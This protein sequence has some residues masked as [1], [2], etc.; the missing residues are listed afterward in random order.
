MNHMEI[1][2]IESADATSKPTLGHCENCHS[3]VPFAD[4]P[5]WDVDAIAICAECLPKG[6]VDS[7]GWHEG[8]P[9]YA[10]ANAVA[11]ALAAEVQAIDPNWAKVIEGPNAS[12]TIWGEGPFV[13][14]AIVVLE[15]LTEEDVW[16]IAKHVHV[17]A[18]KQG[19]FIEPISVYNIGVYDQREGG[20]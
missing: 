18:S 15:A 10:D 5:L 13:A 11:H 19:F 2:R 1:G 3:Q 4:M 14:D 7:K 9:V 8:A 17:A 12:T 16:K 6:Y 20:R